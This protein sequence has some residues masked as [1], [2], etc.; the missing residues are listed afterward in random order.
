M[1]IIGIITRELKF[2]DINYLSTRIDVYDALSKFDV[3]TIGIPI[4]NP[5]EQI[6]NAVNLCHGIILPGGKNYTETDLKLVKY[7]YERN[8]PTLGICLGMQTMALAFNNQTE[9]QILNHNI[10]EEYVHDINIKKDSL[11]F[12]ILEQEKITVNSR[13]NYAIPKTNFKINAISPDN[14]IEGIEE[15]GKKFFLGV[16]WHPESLTDINSY[17]LFKNFIEII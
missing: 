14:I 17:K 6:K 4:T 7:L 10:K 9:E 15:P 5:W 12:K 3:V 2:N 1:K 13:H 11:L 8:I 16:E